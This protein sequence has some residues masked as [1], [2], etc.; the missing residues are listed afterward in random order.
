[1][2]CQE[3]AV[4][5]TYGAQHHSSDQIILANCGGLNDATTTPV[6][7]SP[8]LARV[9]RPT[10][11]FPTNRAH[12]CSYRHVRSTRNLLSARGL[13]SGPPSGPGVADAQLGGKAGLTS[14]AIEDPKHK[15]V[16]L[17]VFIPVT[18][19][20]QNVPTLNT[21]PFIEWLCSHKA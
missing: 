5:R 3:T 19:A 16:Y 18:T 1:M 20:L 12:P 13:K 21:A 15:Q 8:L 11:Q 14:C 10:L 6:P 17:Y 2:Q 4:N 9:H 7:T